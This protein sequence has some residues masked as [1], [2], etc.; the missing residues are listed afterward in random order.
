M[1]I[2]FLGAPGSGKGTHSETVSEKLL[3]PTISTGDLIRGEIRSGSEIGLNAKKYTQ[4]GQLVPDDIVIGMLKN[5]L[6]ESDC[7]NGYILDGFPRTIAQA[8]ALEQMGID[9]DIV[10]NINV[11]DEDIIKRM[12]GRR[13]CSCGEIYHTEYKPPKNK[14]ICDKCGNELTVRSDDKSEVVRDRLEIYHK[15]TKPLEEYYEKQEK[16]YQAYGMEDI[17]DTSK[18][19]LDIIAKAAEKTI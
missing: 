15:Q 5:R 18:A 17:S 3:I 10:I 6:T 12:S 1:K 8:E 14:G 11:K 2:I 9:I 16:L 13:I 4:K 7:A 19:I